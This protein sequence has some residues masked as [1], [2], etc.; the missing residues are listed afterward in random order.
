LCSARCFVK[1]LVLAPKRRGKGLDEVSSAILGDAVAEN[2]VFRQSFVIQTMNELDRYP[3]S[4]HRAI[5]DQAK[6]PWMGIATQLGQ[7]GETKSKAIK[8]YR[9]PLRSHG[10]SA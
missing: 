1:L 7:F 4:G 9:Q 3:W 2:K 8:E 6:Y 10:I 5:I